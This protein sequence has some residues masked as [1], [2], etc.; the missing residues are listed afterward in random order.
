MLAK[1]FLAK[2]AVNEHRAVQKAPVVG[3]TTDMNVLAGIRAAVASAKKIYLVM[4]GDPRTTD[5]CYTNNV[6]SASGVHP[7]A[8]AKQLAAFLAQILTSGKHEY[9]IALV[10][11]YGARCK[12]YK[13][14]NVDHQGMI[15]QAHLVTSFAYR[16]FHALVSDHGIKTRMSAVTGKI[17][18]DSGTGM[19]LV[20]HEDVI[21]VNMEIAE[22]DK[23]K[24]ESMKSAVGGVLLPQD[25]QDATYKLN[26]SGWKTGDEGKGL[27]KASADARA[28]RDNIL[29]NLS[30]VGHN[31]AMR[32][33]GKIQYLVKGGKLTII[34]KYGDST[35]GMK[36]GTAI[37]S[38]PIL[39]PA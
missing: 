31:Q 8:S 25:R 37:Y 30:A 9:D 22:A 23:A 26:E 32:K 1:I 7:L 35:R 6:G 19:A 13:S 27:L 10:M 36:A 18:H 2:N 34:T 14:S 24:R 4:H 28:S 3:F 21:D 17:Q 38:G 39:T 20:E 15:P 33:Y 5:M 16:L 11:C 29:K 12:E